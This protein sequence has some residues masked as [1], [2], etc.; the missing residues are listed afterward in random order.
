MKHRL[1]VLFVWAL[2]GLIF[3]M[4]LIAPVSDF[5]NHRSIVSSATNAGLG[6]M[7]AIPAVLIVS[8][9]PRNTIGW[10]LMFPAGVFAVVGLADNYL[11]SV[12]A[13]QPTLLLLLVAWFSSWSWLL[14][15]FPLLLIALLFP[16]G[17]PP[18]RRWN[19]VGAAVVL[20]AILLILVAS[21]GKIIQPN[22]GPE[23]PNPLG[24]FSV[25]FLLQLIGPWQVGL[26]LLTILCVASLFVRYRRGPVVEQEQIKWLVYACGVF[27][28]V[29]VVGGFVLGLG[30]KPTF[31]SDVFNFL[32]A[33]TTAC[34]P[35]AIAIAVLRYRLWDIDV[36]IQRTLQYTLLTGA[37]ALIYF[38]G[39][40]LLQK[41]FSGILQV[42]NASLN[43][44]ISTLAIAALFN[45]L[46]QRLQNFIDRRFYRQKYNAEQAIARFSSTARD[47]V[48]MEKLVSEL[49]E[50]VDTTMQPEGVNLWLKSSKDRYGD[51]I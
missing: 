33:L 32:L 46:R 40:V 6:L 16:S 42:S 26:L 20:W 48:D 37:L 50:V 27:A 2:C 21:F 17:R 31:A 18:S 35:I 24:L 45:P 19:W 7:F 3:G 43:I 8:R 11:Q 14:Y 9:Q 5:A 22:V 12:V 38:G 49:L 47:E 39:V 34:I 28:V 25:E 44:V 36:I 10:L 51:I 13:A 30:D 4:A 41:L 23:L 1:S 15:I 29:F